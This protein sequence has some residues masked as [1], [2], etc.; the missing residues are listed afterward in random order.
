MDY[1]VEDIRYLTHEG[2]PLM[3]TAFVPQGEGPFPAVVELHGGSWAAFDRTRNRPMHEKL[4]ASGIT[5]VAL[6]YRKGA[7]APW[8]AAS[9]DANYGVRWVKANA[10]RFKT[11]PGRV[12]LSGNSSGGHSAILTAMRPTDDKQ[13]SIEGWAPH[14]ASVCCVVLLWPVVNPLGR[15]RNAQRAARRTPP[16]DFGARVMANHQDYFRTEKNMVKASVVRMLLE[17]ERVNKPPV[18]FIQSTRDEIHNYRDPE[19]G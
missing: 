19:G 5:V 12:A 8:P 18:L 13:A 6:D 7:D 10:A 11:E 15:Y 3:A 1:T 9:A 4:A 14:D 2:G 17:G 16:A